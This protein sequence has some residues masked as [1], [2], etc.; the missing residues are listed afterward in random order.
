MAELR[1][2]AETHPGDPE[3]GAVIFHNPRR[4]GCH[5]CH[6][7][8][9]TSPGVGPDLGSIGH[10]L[11]RAALVTAI[12]EPSRSITVGYGTTI[13]A[14]TDGDVHQ[15][16]LTRVTADWIELVD[17]DAKRIRIAAADVESRTDSAVSIMPDGLHSGL[18]AGEFADLVAYL[19]SLQRSGGDADGVTTTVPVAS[20]PATFEPAFGTLSFEH[21]TW[22]G[23]L[24]AREGSG[25]KARF[26]VLEQ[27]G[28][29]FVV[30][31]K[32]DAWEKRL[33]FDRTAT[34]RGIGATGLLGMAFHPRFVDNRR[35]FVK[36]Q[37]RTD[38]G[39]ETVVEERRFGAEAVDDA[40]FTPRRVL[41]IPVVTP[42]H[43]GGCIAFGPEG[44]LYIGAGDSG[45]QGDP[46]GHGQ[47][48]STL[49][50]KILR[51]DVDASDRPYAIPADNPFQD[52]AGARPEIWA[53]GFREPWRFSFDPATGG[54][55][56][57]DVGQDR[58][59]E[60][61]VVR[62][63]ENH[64]WNVF[65]G[66][67]DHAPAERRDGVRYVPPVFSY[68]R[69]LGASVTGGHV[70]RGSRAPRME[71]R[72]VCGDFESRRVWALREAEGL[73]VDVVE[74]GRAPSRVVSFAE[75]ADGEL[76]VVGF[77]DGIVRRLGLG[78]IDPAPLVER[79]L[80]ETSRTAPVPWR[81][82]TTAPPTEWSRVDFD[83]ASWATGPGGF[84]TAGTPGAVIRTDWRS[85]D[86]WLRR[87]FDLATDP[88]PG[89]EVRL[90]IHHDEDAEV[91][92]NG[93]EAVRTERWTQSYVDLPIVAS[94]A[95]TLR[96]G[97]NVI[98]IH[99]R[100]N[101]GGQCIDAGLVER[102]RPT[103]VAPHH[104]E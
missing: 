104:A 32:G 66:H 84:G 42:D 57:G 99:C 85:R 47:D 14:T 9:G 31:A 35:Y 10:K 5:R 86:I 72:Y 4:V 15:G 76:L 22:V 45:P 24:P 56:V 19:A 81:F 97:R 54:L 12:L 91:F 95:A 102:I 78:A 62:A 74:I 73:L 89:A 20:L 59:E 64:G 36:A 79:V 68:P 2:W 75:D 39:M 1:A 26:V 93:V 100:Q 13:V 65:E 23:P 101:S 51:I 37:V 38:D 46:Q 44:A 3:A 30:E 88:T 18:T 80:A 33:L 48:L 71:G 27:A 77:D 7:I 69:S 53:L 55:W 8:D 43:N 11:E 50:G 60:I 41:T 58:H 25:L 29:A 49:L 70:Y 94:A 52:V 16:I 63:G 67:A 40:S 98:A 83:D 82:T 96:R 6:P 103:G 21:P 17:K 34:V 61:A 92:V 90:V 87:S 28:R